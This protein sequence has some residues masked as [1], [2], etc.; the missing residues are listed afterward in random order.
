MAFEHPPEVHLA[1]DCHLVLKLSHLDF[2]EIAGIGTHTRYHVVVVLTD[3]LQDPL[4]VLIRPQMTPL[5]QPT[6]KLA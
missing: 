1:Q 5:S 3:V 6:L 4:E 2:L